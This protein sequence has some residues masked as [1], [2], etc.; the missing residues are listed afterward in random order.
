MLIL[1]KYYYCT[2]T[3]G[4]R[5]SDQ[6]MQSQ[7]RTAETALVKRPPHLFKSPI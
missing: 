3:E 4:Y 5:D 7:D 1:L 6:F 2:A